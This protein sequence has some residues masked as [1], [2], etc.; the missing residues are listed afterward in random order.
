ML[1]EV[2]SGSST[3]ARSVNARGAPWTRAEG[4]ARFDRFVVYDGCY[5]AT[6]SALWYGFSR[7]P[8]APGV[9]VVVEGVRETRRRTSERALLE[10]A[11]F[12]SGVCGA[13]RFQTRPAF[14]GT[15]LASVVVCDAIRDEERVRLAL[16]LAAKLFDDD[17]TDFPSP[18]TLTLTWDGLVIARPLPCIARTS[19]A[20]AW[21][22]FGRPRTW[23]AALLASCAVAEP[24]W[25]AAAAAA[26]VLASSSS[27]AGPAG[28]LARVLAFLQG[29]GTD[30]P[31]EGLLDR[32]TYE[33]AGADDVA[34]LAL[35]AA[36]V[37]HD[38]DM[39]NA[40]ARARLQP[41]D[42]DELPIVAD[43]A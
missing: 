14:R 29:A 33:A 32:V 26:R 2:A 7:E 40:D 35:V 18:R 30:P 37:H 22:A 41:G 11:A 36:P 8:F 39:R 10:G 43:S 12:E 13:W 31:P 5:D 34:A 38:R 25:Q 4:A 28:T 19:R 23:K 17:V 1:I 15:S 6:S 42:L 16:A 24:A 3:A 27:S 9:E 21:P 20:Y